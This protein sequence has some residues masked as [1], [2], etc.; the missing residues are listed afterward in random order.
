MGSLKSVA[1][2]TLTASSLASAIDGP[3]LST[4]SA[5]TKTNNL[6]QLNPTPFAGSTE[7]HSLKKRC[8]V[9]SIQTIV[10]GTK[11]QTVYYT[12]DASGELQPHQTSSQVPGE[13]ED[14]ADYYCHETATQSFGATEVDTVIEVPTTIPE[15]GTTLT[16]IVPQTTIDGMPAIQT[17]TS[18]AAAQRNAKIGW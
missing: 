17:S 1:I 10:T 12:K 6:T 4:S 2:A 8:W 7:G 5:I 15:T 16:T 14:R 9:D 18:L 3:Q 11:T 13:L